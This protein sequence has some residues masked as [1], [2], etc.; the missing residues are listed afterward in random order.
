MLRGCSRFCAWPAGLADPPRDRSSLQCSRSWWNELGTFNHF[1]VATMIGAERHSLEMAANHV[2]RASNE[3]TVREV[4]QGISAAQA[5]VVNQLAGL[6]GTQGAVWA[7]PVFI[8]GA[9]WARRCIC[10]GA[11][12]RTMLCRTRQCRVPSRGRPSEAARVG[13]LAGL[14]AAAWFD[15]THGLG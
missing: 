11:Q 2:I 6:R 12:N 3:K 7:L 9:F 8:P 15:H 1:D 4:H 5:D 13:S 10:V 14:H